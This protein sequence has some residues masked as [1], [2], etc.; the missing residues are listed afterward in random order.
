MS[1]PPASLPSILSSLCR[2]PSPGTFRPERLVEIAAKYGMSESDVL[3]NVSYAKAHNTDHQLLLLEQ[4]AALMADSRYALIVVDSATALFRTD[5]SGRGE[6]AERQMKLAK[7]LRRLQVRRKTGRLVCSRCGERQINR[8]A[9][10]RQFA[11]LTRRALHLHVPLSP[12]SQ[13]YRLLA[14]AA[15]TFH[16][17]HA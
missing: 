16:G 11:R 13:V 6:L 15:C 9:A 17:S 4:A 8:V 5:F 10:W 7:F 14:F 3:E 1:V 12:A 2:F